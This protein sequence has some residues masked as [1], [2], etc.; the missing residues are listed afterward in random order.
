VLGSATLRAENWNRS[1]FFWDTSQFKP[2]NAILAANSEFN[3]R[4]MT[5]SAS[6][7]SFE[8][9]LRIWKGCRPLLD[10]RL[11]PAELEG[12]KSLYSLRLRT[13]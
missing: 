9:G 8:L 6:S 12:T 2:R 10:N 7:L 11:T 1:N 3:P 13:I 4:S 5:E